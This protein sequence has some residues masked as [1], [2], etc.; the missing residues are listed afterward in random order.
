M[1]AL[2]FFLY[3]VSGTLIIIAL[4][5]VGFLVYLIKIVQNLMHKVELIDEKS[6]MI[7]RKFQA[8]YGGF[9]GNAIRLLEVFMRRR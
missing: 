2:D 8:A 5:I 6:E 4:C 7:Q 3:T 9:L 1:Q